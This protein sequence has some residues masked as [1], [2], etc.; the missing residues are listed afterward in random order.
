MKISEAS[1][2]IYE[3][4]AKGWNT[5][6]VKSVTAHVH[7]PSGPRVN[8][9]FAVPHLSG[10]LNS[11]FWENVEDFGE[12][13]VDGTYTE[14]LI[15]HLDGVYRVET[16]AK[17]TELLMRITPEVRREGA[18][19]ILEVGE[20]WGARVDI[21]YEGDELHVT[22]GASL[23]KITALNRKAALRWIPSN[24]A[25]IPCKADETVYY[26][27]NSTK[28]AGEIDRVLAEARQSWLD[29]TITAEGRLGE[30]LDALRRALLWNTVFE[31]RNKRVV[32]PVSRN[33]C[34]GN[35]AGFGDY[36]VFCWDTF[37]AA[38]QLGLIHKE[39][40]YAAMFSMLEE[41]TPD[42]MVPN[43]GSANGIS[44]DRSEP[45]VGSLCAWKLYIQ[46]G[47]KWF[48]EECF[49]RLLAWNRWRFRERDFNGDGL[50][51]LATVPWDYELK[52]E[53]W[54]REPSVGRKQGAQYESGLD[55]ST[56]FDHAVFNEE[57]K[58]MELSYV[59]LNAEMV[60][61]CQLLEKMAELLG[62][63]EERRELA[64][65]R[66][67]LEKLI[68]EKLWDED[69]GFY[70]N[71]HWS[72][73]F[74][75][76][77]SLMGF[78]SIIAGIADEKRLDTVINRHLLNEKEFWGDYVL[79][80]VSRDDASFESQHYW[81]GRIW[82]PTNFLVGEGIM[83]T[84]RMEIWDRYVQKGFDLFMKCWAEHGIVGE[85]YNA[86]T[87]EAAEKGKW[88]DRFYHWGA[89]LVYMA[90]E[91]VVNF[92]QWKDCI[93]IRKIPPWLAGIKNIPVGQKLISVCEDGLYVD[94][95]KSGDVEEGVFCIDREGGDSHE[96]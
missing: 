39:L 8:I 55:N 70:M 85:N 21:G 25:N 43:C 96:A 19:I 9:A 52:D 4:L 44:G 42:G 17:G 24:C 68:N 75:P 13:S 48:I 65:R 61:D 26:T 27:V 12:H 62:R 90:V 10:Y 51:E 67:R 45:Q 32:T 81:R 94:G 88:S 78:F 84:E 23:F 63:E 76:C 28:N 15:N 86:V 54:G 2:K 93:E 47:D 18:Y 77:L 57:K 72:G 80:N 30:G 33:W 66:S 22:G 49:D 73:E 50:L 64:E 56:M 5:W 60:F 40:A 91:N 37:F 31:P 92:N 1:K 95:R 36:V 87:G 89:L 20:A 74:D 6:D 79:P 41:I 59:G 82:A 38:M 58:C 71:R 69:R 35:G 83:R 11:V 34:K 16:S 53:F 46:Y 29:S 7:L 3:S 14:V